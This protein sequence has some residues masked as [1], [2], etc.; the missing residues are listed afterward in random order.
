[1]TDLNLN[2]NYATQVFLEELKERNEVLGVILFGS[3]ARGN[4]YPESDVDL[5]VILSSGYSRAVEYHSGQVFEIIYTTETSAYD[6]WI[7]DIDGAAGLWGVAKV[8]FDKNGAIE[9]L[10]TKIQQVLDTGKKAIEEHQIRQLHFDSDDQIKY[11]ERIADIDQTSAN[12]ILHNKIY[13]L[14]E[15]FFDIRCIW[16]PAP[17]QRLAEILKI[18]SNFYILL[19]Q[20]YQDQTSFKAKV[21]I[22][23]KIVAIIFEQ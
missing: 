17:K 2:I 13:A 5:V 3:W 15:L 7:S 22:A 18:N 4:N 8:L 11:V 14:S 1:M 10:K 6:Y 9:R 12:L 23:K 20:F 16:T 21:E 19:E